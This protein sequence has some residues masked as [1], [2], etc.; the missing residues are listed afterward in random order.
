[1]IGAAH[2]AV[3]RRVWDATGA[4]VDKRAVAAA[5]LADDGVGDVAGR[6]V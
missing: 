6:A 5:M 1:M 3:C 2:R 4:A